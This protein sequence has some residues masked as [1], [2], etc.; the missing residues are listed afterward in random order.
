VQGG[1]PES[2]K[3]IALVNGFWH[4][5]EFLSLYREIFRETPQQTL[6]ARRQYSRS[7]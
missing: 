4:L 7:R 5:G 2:I 3:A 6:A 1:H